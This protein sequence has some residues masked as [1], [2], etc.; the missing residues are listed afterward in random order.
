MTERKSASGFIRS[1]VGAF[2]RLH[3]FILT[4]L[5]K[6]GGGGRKGRGG[7]KEKGYTC[8][9]QSAFPNNLYF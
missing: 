3:A 6:K 9:V 4:E 2:D 8:V 1:P 7:E 5:S